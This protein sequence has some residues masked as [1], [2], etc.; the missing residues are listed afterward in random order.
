[1]SGFSEP[2]IAYRRMWHPVPLCVHRA[3]DVC[4]PSAWPTAPP[5][6]AWESAGSA[7]IRVDRRRRRLRPAEGYRLSLRHL[8]NINYCLT[9]QHYH[10]VALRRNDG[11]AQVRRQRGWRSGRRHVE[12]GSRSFDSSRGAALGD[13]I[14]LTVRCGLTCVRGCLS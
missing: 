3:Y 9:L 11:Q 5:C 10:H 12:G 2:E 4:Q 13:Y 1:M 8:H 7:L 6:A 14:Y